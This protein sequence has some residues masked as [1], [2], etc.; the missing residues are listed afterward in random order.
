MYLYFIRCS[1]T[2]QYRRENWQLIDQVYCSLYMAFHFISSS[3]ERSA[4]VRSIPEESSGEHGWYCHLKC[5]IDHGILTN[6]PHYL[7]QRHAYVFTVVLALHLFIINRRKGRVVSS[8]LCWHSSAIY[9]RVG[10]CGICVL[11]TRF[12][13]ENTLHKCRL[14]RFLLPGLPVGHGKI[15]A[16]KESL[17]SFMYVDIL[18][19]C[20][21]LKQSEN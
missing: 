3:V 12:Q 5:G 17:T 2:F 10:I 19:L 9:S 15:R 13:H 4:N 11:R 18:L 21:I 6:P 1:C 20:I 16:M 14:S 8:G 7:A